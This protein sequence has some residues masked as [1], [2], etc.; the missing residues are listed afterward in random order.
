MEDKIEIAVIGLSHTPPNNVALILKEIY[1]NRSIPIIIGIYEA[2]SIALEFEKAKPPRPLVHDIVKELIDMTELLF[3][4]TLIYDYKNGT[5]FTKLI[6]KDDGN[7]IVEI[8]CRI[9]DAVAISLRCDVPIYATSY[10]LNESGLM[11]YTEGSP[12]NVPN[13]NIA[14]NK[15]KNKIEHLQNQLE[16][17][18]K[19]EDY[20]EAAKIR[21]EIKN[22][23]EN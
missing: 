7:D 22:Y 5:Y 19:L 23:L 9:S 1:G 20:E 13:N 10:V 3:V 11:A 12:H 17:A 8:E 21:D 14:Y 16:R 6:L 2:Q 18:I 4:E 15:E